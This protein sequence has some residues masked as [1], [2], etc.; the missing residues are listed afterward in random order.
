M[1][2][3]MCE[4]PATQANLELLRSRG[5]RD[6]A[7]GTG[8]LASK[9]EWGVGRLAEPAEILGVDEELLVGRQFA[10]VRSTACGC[11]SPPAA[12]ASR[13][14]RFASSAT[15]RPGGWASRSPRRPPGAAPT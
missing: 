13:S 10:R 9:G 7:P 4:H 11:S 3:R 1:N 5:A 15:A 2:N 14:T 12:R 8:P 6:R